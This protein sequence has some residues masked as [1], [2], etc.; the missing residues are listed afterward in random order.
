MLLIFYVL[1]DE[2]VLDWTGSLH[3]IGSGISLAINGLD[4]VIPF[5][6]EMAVFYVYIFGLMIIPTM[7]YFAFV[8]FRNGYA[9]G[10]SFVFIEVIAAVIYIVLPVSVYQYHEELLATPIGANW[11]IGEVHNIVSDFGSPFNTFPSLHAAGST[12]VVYTWYQH[13]KLHPSYATKILVVLS[14]IA[15][16]GIILST[17]FIKQHYVLDE[18]AGTI[19]GYVVSRATFNHLWKPSER[20]K[21]P[22]KSKVT[23]TDGSRVG[24][25]PI[26]AKGLFSY[27]FSP[28]ALFLL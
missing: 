23:S 20:P 6:P 14:V 25:R 5:V 17:L 15:A 9:V 27:H 3:P 21:L 7:L 16:V 18:I 28:F 10:W 8:E 24:R 1:L 11:W 26:S 13:S 12:V 19:L 4:N 2:A 22:S